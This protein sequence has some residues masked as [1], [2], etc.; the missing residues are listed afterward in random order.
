MEETNDWVQYVLDRPMAAEPGSEFHYCSGCSHLLSAI[1]QETTGIETLA[2]AQTHLFDPIGITNVYWEPD[3][4]GIANGGWGLEITP[5]DMAKFGYLYLNEGVWDGKQIIPAEWIK[6]ST[7]QSV[8]LK[9]EMGYGYQWW[10]YPQLDIYAARGFNY[11]AIY[12]I[13]NL[14]LVIV[15]TAGIKDTT[16]DVFFEFVED[17]AMLA[18]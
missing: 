9:E 18:R 3:V 14:D 2:F 12:V 16:E 17:Y 10:I 11:Q 5:R 13:P 4:T 15:F 6:T 7:Q 8:A 1:I